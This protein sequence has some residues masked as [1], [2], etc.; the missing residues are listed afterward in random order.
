[1]QDPD[2]QRQHAAYKTTPTPGHSAGRPK[3]AP[4]QS[5]PNVY[6][7]QKSAGSPAAGAPSSAKEQG[8]QPAARKT[9][10]ASFEGRQKPRPMSKKNK[11]RQKAAK[12]NGQATGG[13]EKSAVFGGRFTKKQMK[14][15]VLISSIVIVL[16]LSIVLAMVIPGCGGVPAGSSSSYWA[17]STPS[18]VSIDTSYDKN[19]NSIPE[20]LLEGTILHKG[21]DAGQSYVDESLFL[22]DSNTARMLNYS[23]VTGLTKANALGVE[24]MGITSVSSLAC[25]KFQK[26]GTVSMAKAVS[27]LQPR[28]VIVNFGTNNAGTPVNTFINYY[29]STVENL[30][31]MAENTEIIIASVLPITPNCKYGA[32]SQKQIDEYNLAL[33]ELAKEMDVKF[34]NW[35]EAIRDAGTGYAQTKYMLGDGVHINEAGAEALFD[36][37]RT[38]ASPTEDMRPAGTKAADTCLGAIADL[39]RPEP[40]EPSSKTSSS[41]SNAGIVN[42]SF[43]AGEGGTLKMGEST[44]GSFGAQAAPGGSTATVTAI[45]AEGRI[46]KGWSVGGN[47]ISTSAS[48]SYT[49]PQDTAGGTS[50]T[51]TAVFGSAGVS[52]PHITDVNNPPEG[53]TIIVAEQESDAAVGTILGQSPAQGAVIGEN[54]AK[55]ITVTVA[56]AKPVEPPPDSSEEQP[57]PVSSEE[58]PPPPPDEGGEE[59]DN[60]ENQENAD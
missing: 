53:W 16:V 9:S 40:V 38:H 45:P 23:K 24:S 27:L 35:S 28:R 8:V 31:K 5:G 29:R 44:G 49:V 33:A 32:V 7:A 3:D 42:V 36:Y 60:T 15:G 13:E 46:F 25:V 48:I 2:K 34:L 20:E 11:T 52:V 57:P 4:V 51:V 12:P 14:Y 26:S 47:I 59:Q 58:P 19:A 6:R 17:S 1:M 41:S 55:T 50:I 30:Q 18:S 54:D 56:K 37:Y 10:A 22:G 43:V 21:K 39:L